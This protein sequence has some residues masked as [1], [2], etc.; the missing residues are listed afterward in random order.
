MRSISTPRGPSPTTIV[1][2]RFFRTAT[3]NRRLPTSTPAWRSIEGASRAIRYSRIW[4]AVYILKSTK[5]KPATRPKR[6]ELNEIAES[7]QKIP[8]LTRKLP[9]YI[10]DSDARARVVETYQAIGDDSLKSHDWEGAVRAF[11]EWGK[12]R[13]QGSNMRD[14]KTANTFKLHSA[15]ELKAGLTEAYVGWGLDCSGGDIAGKKRS[16]ACKTR[17]RWIRARPSSSTTRWHRH[18]RGGCPDCLAQHRFI[19][20]IQ[21]VQ[22]AKDKGMADQLDEPLAQAYAERGYAAARTRRL[23]QRGRGPQPGALKTCRHCAKVHGLGGRACCLMAEAN[24]ISA[25]QPAE[26]KEQWARRAID[27]FPNQAMRLDPASERELQRMLVYARYN[28]T[29]LAGQYV[30]VLYA[31]R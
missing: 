8:E 21:L 6:H 3:A 22:N 18:T 17:S 14:A 16:K 19:E 5:H 30:P 2:R 27:H 29:R 11:K 26:E 4:Q 24:A 15:E 9:G 10:A 31:T 1:P 13:L 25:A 23:R 28:Y 7:L 20:V 12:S